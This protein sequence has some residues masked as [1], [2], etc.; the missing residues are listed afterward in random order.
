[1]RVIYTVIYYL[2]MPFIL[3]RLLWRSRHTADYRKRWNERFGFVP[4]LVGKD[5]IWIHAVSVGE[6]LAAIPLIKA[7]VEQYAAQF[8][9]IVTT[10]TP[11][12]SALVTK[13]LDK[14]VLHVYAPFDVPFA[15]SRFLRRSR[16][17][18]CVIM[19]TELWPNLLAMCSGKK[20]PVLLANARLSERSALRYQFIPE[21]TR[22]MLSTYHTVAAQGVLDGERY[23]HLGL[24]PKKLVITGN[25]KFDL[26]I[27]DELILQGKAIKKCIGESRRVLIAA[28]T[29]DGEEA[30]ILNAFQKIRQEIPNLFL[31]LAPRHPDRFQKIADLCRQTHFKI[32][33]RSQQ[34]P[35]NQD[36]DI[37][38]VDTIGELQM[39]YAAADIAF[40]GGSLVPIG[41]HNLIEP[42]ALGLPIL[43]G[44]N[45][46]NFTEISKLL[47][48]A[49]AAQIVT[50]ALS[51]ADA[52][53]ALCS[54]KEL[55]EKISKCA[56]ETIEANR[57][58]LQKHLEC[59]ERCLGDVKKN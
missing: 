2:I 55:R 36:T 38:L 29:H 22:Q 45:L 24:D 42:A 13:N 18:L 53:I 11:T 14:K 26:Q 49:G 48:N 40:V 4:Y 5:S 10:T 7:L 54:A 39:I 28:S 35:I 59:I 56:K 33:T 23:L 6:T 12:G 46:H 25:I 1:M 17:K 58:A 19:E 8:Q 34:E 16:V 20:I 31:M 44:P 50:D 51:I 41:G 21:L 47:Q 37:L 52:V 15:V 30:I 3:L 27:P 32:S 43:T 57:G 9:I